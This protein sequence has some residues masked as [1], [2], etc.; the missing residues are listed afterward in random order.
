MYILWILIDNFFFSFL[1]FV[2]EGFFWCWTSVPTGLWT[3]PTCSY[4]MFVSDTKWR[5][6][7]ARILLDLLWPCPLS[8]VRRACWT[9]RR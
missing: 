8:R 1:L 6:V 5:E 2:V 3:V 7:V 9:P 4:P